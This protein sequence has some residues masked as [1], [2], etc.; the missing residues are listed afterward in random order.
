[1]VDEHVGDVLFA[2]AEME[3]E[4]AVEVSGEETHAG[5]FD[6]GDDE[7]GAGVMGVLADFPKG[8]GAGLLNFRV[9]REVFEGEDVVCGKTEDGVR[10]KGSGELAGGENSGMKGFGSLVVGDDDDARS[11]GGADEV[12]EI[13]G[14]GGSG[15]A[16]DTSAPRASAQVAAYTLEGFGVLEVRKEL[17]DEG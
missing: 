8:G 4:A 14:S 10:R 11:S 6:G 5:R 17:A 12:G 1:M 15:E 13:E 3:G 7:A 2:D 16:G 9:R